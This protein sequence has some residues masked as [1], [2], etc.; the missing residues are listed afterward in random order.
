MG[1]SHVSFA[2]GQTCQLSN[3]KR[4][5]FC[6][7][8]IIQPKNPN[9]QSKKISFSL[10]SLSL[11]LSINQSKAMDSGDENVELLN[12]AI[13]RL[14]EERKKK[15]EISGDDHHD[16]D[17]QLLLSRLLSQLESLKAARALDKPEASKEE[18]CS[19]DGGKEIKSDQNAGGERDDIDKE[20]IVKEV[21]KIK[22]QNSV[23][24]WLL[25]IMIVVTVAWQISEVSLILK[26]KEGVSEGIRNPFR[27]LGGMLAGM[28]K[29]PQTGQR[30]DEDK[31]SH[32]EAPPLKIP[33][34]P[35]VELL[36]LST[37]GN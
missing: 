23:T 11:S 16:D 6:I 32:I 31:L 3:S 12:V 1:T 29:R 28:L 10:I 20:E 13:Q 22:K 17:E 18:T 14:I 25:S 30:E 2:Y 19:R 26:L 8:R 33:E 35:R 15:S 27:Y 34:I 7:H 21:K 37:N 36:D 24:H 9:S 5:D 4:F